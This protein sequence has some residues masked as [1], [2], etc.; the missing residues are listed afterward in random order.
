MLEWAGPEGCVLPTLATTWSKAGPATFVHV[1]AVLL[2]AVGPVAELADRDAPAEPAARA[3]VGSHDHV[4]RA[5]VR[6]AGVGVLVPPRRR[7]R[8]RPDHL[9]DTIEPDQRVTSACAYAVTGR[10]PA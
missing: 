4:R 3:R 9:A 2:D 5:K 8:A 6:A 1:Q 10:R 7:D